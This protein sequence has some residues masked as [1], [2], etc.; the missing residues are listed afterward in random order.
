MA[1]KA[2]ISNDALLERL[3]NT[4]REVGYDGA[5]LTLLS[6]ATGLKKA[7]LYHR[8]PGGKEQMAM[9]VLQGA[10]RWMTDNILEPLAGPG[11]PRRRV[12]AICSKLDHFYRGGRQACLLNLLSAP[13]GGQGPFREPIRQFL[14]ALIGAFA[15]VARETG[16]EKND[17]AERAERCLA[18]LQGGL[19]LS[20]GLGS[21][22]PFHRMLK[23]LPAE[24]LRL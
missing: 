13:A 3:S 15:D 23:Q 11:T 22:A 16:Y 19:V 21:N 5:S 14:E 10:G 24:L 4:F 12:E 9:E 17:A 2:L 6:E 20:K 7:S 1:R 8:F 18:L